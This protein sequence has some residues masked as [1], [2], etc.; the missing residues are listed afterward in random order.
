MARVGHFFWR[1]LFWGALIIASLLA[2]VPLPEL[3]PLTFSLS[4]KAQHALVFTVLWCLG[5]ASYPDRRRQLAV[6]LLCYGG[7]IEAAQAL[8]PT[9]QAEWADWL[10]DAIGIALGWWAMSWAVRLRRAVP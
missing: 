3:P 7:A 9:R 2:L 6:A 4:D 5:A 8:T 10:A 1:A